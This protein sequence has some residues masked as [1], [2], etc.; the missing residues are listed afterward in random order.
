MRDSF[1][2]KPRHPSAAAASVR[3]IAD[4]KARDALRGNE[5]RHHGEITANH[6][7]RMKLPPES[8]LR[9]NRACEDQETAGF[10]VETL[11]DT[12]TL[13]PA[14]VPLFL[15][16]GDEPGDDILQRRRERL[17]PAVPIAF[18]RMADRRKSG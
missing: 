8:L 16:R 11:D 7:V 18:R 9:G 15:E 3:A 10:L 13:G 4:Q 5:A 12:Q 17:A 1:L 6:G 2:S 14:P